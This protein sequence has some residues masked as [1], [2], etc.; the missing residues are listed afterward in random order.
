[1]EQISSQLTQII[2]KEFDLEIRPAITIPDPKFGDFA[3]NVALQIAKPLGKNPREIAQTIADQ[4]PDATVA[5][6]GFINIR[7]P[8]TE[9]LATL[10]S[11]NS[12]PNFGASKIYD[13]KIVVTEYSDP[14]PFKVLHIGHLYTSVVGDAMSNLIEAAGGTTHRVNFGGD[15]GLHVA[16]AMWGIIQHFGGEHPEKLTNIPESEHMDFISARYVEG[17]KAYEENPAAKAEIVATN[18]R[19]YALFDQLD[20]PE[21]LGSK[22]PEG[23]II[24]QKRAKQSIQAGKTRASAPER[25]PE[26]IVDASDTVDPF[27]TIYWTCRQ[28]SY[29]YFDQF[30]A[31]IGVKFE[32]YY[33]ESATAQI[34]LK[35]VKEQ[36][37]NGVYEESNGAIIFDGEKH[38]LH[39][40]VFIN[41]EGLPTYE[42]KDLG[43]SL[44][45]ARDYNFDKSIIITGNDI[46]EYMKVLL[47]SIEQFRPDLSSKTLH[48]THGMVKLAG[49]VKQSSRLGN[50]VKAVDTIDITKKV[51]EKEQ[52][53]ADPEI[54]LGAIKYA[55]LKNSVGPDIIFDPETSVS[56]QG[57]SGPYLQYSL[58]RAKS[59]LRS[60]GGASPTTAAPRPSSDRGS[61]KN[62]DSRSE[63]GMSTRNDGMDSIP[64]SEEVRSGQQATESDLDTHERALLK[65]LSDY[66]YILEKST[67]DLA[68]HH[69]CA[70]LYELAQ[71]FNRF[72]EN[73]KVAGDPR[74]VIRTRLVRAYA[75]ILSRALITLGIPTPDKM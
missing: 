13:K 25:T 64:Y 29:D 55:F 70:Y 8:D 1:M 18:K 26:E 15:V 48:L 66:S 34:G 6:P 51:L 30:Y 63:E 44:A 74:E 72:Y 2:S 22:S 28:W 19:I 50:F 17:N 46:T 45:K 27:A 49:G 5:G 43:L 56:L 7:L 31:S 35:T 68:P 20:S 62:D 11:I 3:T 40:R 57:N 37:K 12:D 16:K 61:P 58:T 38:D 54:V 23:T 75:H 39:T 71:T 33:P 69:L 53:S 9:L 14:N 32:K 65:K 21:T 24:A 36:L 4:L 60:L 67:S 73:A 47:K 42:A 52:G 59:I 41:S 10:D